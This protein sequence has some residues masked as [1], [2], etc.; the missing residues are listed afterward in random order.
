M[1]GKNLFFPMSL[2]GRAVTNHYVSEDRNGDR[3]T[4]STPAISSENIIIPETTSA[5]T[6]MGVAKTGDRTAFHSFTCD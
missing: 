3:Q 6:G 2:F 1:E 5:I 4:P